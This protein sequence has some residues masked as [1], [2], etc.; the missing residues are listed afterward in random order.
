MK[1]ATGNVPLESTVLRLI[2]IVHTE[3]VRTVV[4]DSLGKYQFSNVLTG[5]YYMVFAQ[6]ED[7]N[8]APNNYG[9][10]FFSDETDLDFLAS[11]NSPRPVQDFDGDGRIDLAVFRPSNGTWYWLGSGSSDF[12]ACQFG[13]NGDIRTASAKIQ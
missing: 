13:Q 1:S 8:F 7:Y 3:N 10:N 5:G 6:R 9:I 11:P 12:Q 4:S 2:D